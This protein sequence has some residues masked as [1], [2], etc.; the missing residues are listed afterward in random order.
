[1]QG[2][3]YEE[4]ITMRKIPLWARII[5]YFFVTLVLTGAFAFLQEATGIRPEYL[6]LA[7]VGPALAALI[8]LVLEGDNVSSFLR[9]G[10]RLELDRFSLVAILTPMVLML[11]VYSA[12][13]YLYGIVKPIS[14]LS[15]LDVFFVLSTILA[16]LCEEIGWRGYMLPRLQ[17]RMTPMKASLIL[18]VLWSLWHVPNLFRGVRFFSVWFIGVMGLTVV[19]TYA[20]NRAGGRLWPVTLIHA[21][22]NIAAYFLLDIT[23]TRVLML[24]SIAYFLWAIGLI[25]IG[26]RLSSTEATAV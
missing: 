9:N 24:V 7:Q 12:S 10:L 8:F 4:D 25:A 19:F 5:T 2:C 6:Q 13:K 23:D 20:F 26:G 3:P 22:V 15:I 1:M 21:S 17:S 11:A 14:S 18:G 16:A